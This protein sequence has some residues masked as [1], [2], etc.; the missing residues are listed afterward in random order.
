MGSR[1]SWAHRT[2]A[3]E[4]YGAVID[5]RSAEL[6]FRGAPV[7]FMGEGVAALLR[8]CGESVEVGLGLILRT[9]TDVEPS[10][11]ILK[12]RALGGMTVWIERFG[13]TF[14]QGRHEGGEWSVF[15][16]SER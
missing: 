6:Q 1:I 10:G 15:L 16:P 13:C 8:H 7:T 3:T 14:E 11:C 5:I 9:A 12:S 4:R 2:T